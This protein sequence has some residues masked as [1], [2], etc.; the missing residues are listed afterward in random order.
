MNSR[1][2]C[3]RS[4]ADRS[5]QYSDLIVALRSGYADG[6]R[7]CADVQVHGRQ[8]GTYLYGFSGYEYDAVVAYNRPGTS[9]L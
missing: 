8:L 2:S 4:N 6:V 7:Y 3:N 9:R 1:R 5:A